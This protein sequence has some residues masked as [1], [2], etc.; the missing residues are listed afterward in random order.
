MSNKEFGK[1]SKY[2]A[3]K[4]WMLRYRP[5][6]GDAKYVI[7]RDEDEDGDGDECIAGGSLEELWDE[8]S[9]LVATCAEYQVKLGVLKQ[10]A[11]SV[12][13]KKQEAVRR[14]IE[15]EVLEE[16]LFVAMEDARQREVLDKNIGHHESLVKEISFRYFPEVF[17]GYEDMYGLLQEEIGDYVASEERSW[18]NRQL[19]PSTSLKTEVRARL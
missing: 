15:G 13:S 6:G 12:S 8:W 3:S 2:Y 9:D 16:D 5:N 7:E 19:A 11:F 18:L 1:Y 4:G 17:F 14:F 10:W